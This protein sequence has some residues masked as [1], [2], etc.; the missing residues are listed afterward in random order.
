MSGKH[1]G[2]ACRVILLLCL[3]SSRSA[4]AQGTAFGGIEL[5]SSSVKGLTFTFQQGDED[6]SQT[7]ASKDRVDRLQYAERNASFISMKEGCK[8]NERG[9]ALLVK[10]TA[11]VVQEL[12][13]GAKEKNLP[14]LKLFVVGSSGLGAVCNTGEIIER[15]RDVTGLCAEFISA[16]DEAKYTLGFVLPK[17]RYRSLI[18]DVS[19]GNTLGGYYVTTRGAAWP[20]REWHGFEMKYGSR[21]LKDRA[22]ALVRA[23]QKDDQGSAAP[24]LDYW[25]AVD[26]V[27][28]DEVLPELEQ[29][30]QENS[31]LANFGQLYMVGGAI[32][33]VSTRMQ[34]VQQEQWAINPLTLPDFDAVLAKLK[35]GT[36]KEFDEGQL[37]P[38]VSAKTREAAEAELQ[39]VLQRFDPESLYAGVSLARFLVQQTTPFARVY[40]PTTAAWISGYAREKFFE[41][42]AV[43]QS[44]SVALPEKK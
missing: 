19:G 5:G 34:P 12:R 31:G 16:N 32:W 6:E 33:G 26:V 25:H 28:H 13:E 8:L 24:A 4:H 43:L 39:D 3:V 40:F 27:L 44:C 9:L 23:R 35:D 38:R 11:E 21:N 30:K 37:G 14:N 1:I 22:L 42:G 29:V 10:D 17:D 7:G 36:Y 20:P 18:I 2:R 41:S 15:V